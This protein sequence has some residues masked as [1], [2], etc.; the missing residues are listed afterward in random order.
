MIFKGLIL[1]HLF[2]NSLQIYVFSSPLRYPDI[3]LS[4]LPSPTFKQH[5]LAR[6]S[7]E[8]LS[9]LICR[10]THQALNFTAWRTSTDEYCQNR[11]TNIRINLEKK[12]NKTEQSFKPLQHNTQMNFY[13][14]F[15]LNT[16]S[17]DQRKK[18]KR[19]QCPTNVN[20]N[21]FQQH[22]RELVLKQVTLK[23]VRRWKHPGR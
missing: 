11:W 14:S 10:E 18:K 15:G 3:I 8:M 17:F 2:V 19:Q 1:R 23:S 16:Y 22:T 5:F 12:K 4:I 7:W 13:I 20:V 9:R 6:G 21:T